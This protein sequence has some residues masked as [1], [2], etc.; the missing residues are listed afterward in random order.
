M[1][2]TS[3][4][5]ALAI[6]AG[7]C[8]SLACATAPAPTVAPSAPAYA[9]YLF[10]Q[11][12]PGVSD[13]RL[14]EQHRRAWDIL[15]RGDARSASSEFG[16]IL[17]RAPG[18]VAAEV[19]LGYALLAQKQLKDAM[20]WFNHAAQVQP[21]YAAAVAGRAEG[22]LAAGQ[23]AQA[24]AGFEAAVRLAPGASDLARR[25]EVVRFAYLRELASSAKKAA[26]EGRL[27]DARR[28][29]AQAIDVSPDSAV[30]LRDLAAV[31]IRLKDDASAIQHLRRAAALDVTDVRTLVALGETLERRGD[32]PGALAAYER[33]DR[34]ESSETT[35]RAV[36]RLRERAT[37][38][39]L[40]AEYRAIAKQGQT[41]RGD[42]A[43]LLGVRL[44]SWLAAHRKGSGAVA[45]DVRGHWASAFILAVVRAGVMDVFPNHTFQP[46][47]PVTRADA[48]QAV[49]RVLA[50]SGAGNG[51][52]QGAP[53]AIADV[54]ADHLGYADVS[55]AVSSGIMTLTSGQF[56]PSRVLAGAEAV[57]L[58]DRLERATRASGK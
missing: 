28:A 34:L 40:P 50:A 8:L 3:T 14:A 35:R 36:E 26:D 4:W 20:A 44:Q 33:A 37:A 6:A 47:V 58:V 18:Y 22:Y 12:P 39:A 51:R 9:D 15:Q 11:P 5:C 7:L 55:R 16:A 42:L 1:N 48:A 54:S 52:G 27:E 19:G 30:L 2:R 56:R 45:T 41:T 43:A 57:D 29:F 13:A 32:A 49:A 24:V 10:P 31:E 38:S 17:K 23:K 25:L 53:V 46:A 21:T